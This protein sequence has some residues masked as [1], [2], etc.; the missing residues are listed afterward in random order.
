MPNPHLFYSFEPTYWLHCAC[1]GPWSYCAHS[2][3]KHLRPFKLLSVRKL[4][5][6]LVNQK[7]WS[8]GHFHHK[9]LVGRSLHQ[10]ALV[11]WTQLLLLE[12]QARWLIGNIAID[13]D[14]IWF[15]VN[16]S[17]FLTGRWSSGSVLE[18]WVSLLVLNY[19]SLHQSDCG[20]AKVGSL[21]PQHHLGGLN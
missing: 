10:Q 1:H 4:P 3:E 18:L 14:K 21:S 15:L 7:W 12:K 9:E 5:D 6:L 17:K 19:L 20:G 2:I 8:L 11:Q 16:Q 13:N